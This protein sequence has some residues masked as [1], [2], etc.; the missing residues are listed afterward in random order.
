MSLARSLG[1]D[2]PTEERHRVDRDV[3]PT[4]ALLQEQYLKEVF[5]YVLRRVSQR[6][7]AEDVTAEV[8]A[9]AFAAL[10]R[11]RGDCPPYLWLLT[12]ARRKIIDARRRREARRETLASELAPTAEVAWQSAAAE[13]NPEAA[14]A[15]V[16]ARQAVHL[17]LELLN[18]DQREAVS[19]RYWEGLSIEEIAVVMGR[20][21]SA[22]TSLL[23]RARAAMFRRGRAYFLEEGEEHSDA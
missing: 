18:A 9:A 3:A 11:F 12:I 16:E 4:A 14:L 20:S 2:A 5:R 13:G 15:H 21:T 23:H 1:S 22:V 17:L 6:E 8:F 7:D 19:L 10:P